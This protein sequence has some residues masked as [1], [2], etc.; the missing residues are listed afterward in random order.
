MSLRVFQGLTEGG[1][2]LSTRRLLSIQKNAPSIRLCKVAKKKNKRLFILPYSEGSSEGEHR[3]ENAAWLGFVDSSLFRF[4]C[5]SLRSLLSWIPSF[6]IQLHQRKIGAS[7]AALCSAEGRETV[8]S[9]CLF[10]GGLCGL[11]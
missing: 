5:L 3:P 9:G 10:W 1:G 11:I 8:F 7:E 6:P 2:G 4:I